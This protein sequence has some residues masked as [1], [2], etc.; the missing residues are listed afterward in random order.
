MIG[1]PGNTFGVDFAI[2]ERPDGTADHAL[3][4]SEYWWYGVG[5]TWFGINPEQDLIV[6]GMI[7]SRGGGAARKARLTSKSLAYQAITDAAKELAAG[8]SPPGD[9]GRADRRSASS[10][11]HVGSSSHEPRVDRTRPTSTYSTVSSGTALRT[12]S[13][14]RS[15]PH[16]G[17]AAL[18]GLALGVVGED[19]LAVELFL[20]LG[21]RA[22]HLLRRH[23]VEETAAGRIGDQPELVAR[24]RLLGRGRGARARVLP[25]GSAGE[26]RRPTAR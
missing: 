14:A 7:Q 6:V 15:H 19:V 26:R 5:G 3:A 11:Q 12:S 1:N 23:H 22:R 24:H 9:A 16:L 8:R 2:V 25:A 18:A 10:P 21:E 4:K 17:R 20:D 13:P